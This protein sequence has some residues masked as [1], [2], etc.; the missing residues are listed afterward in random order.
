[1]KNKDDSIWKTIKYI[2]KE[3]LKSET[4]SPGGKLNLFFGI[5]IF[6]VVSAS[7]ASSIALYVC[8]FFKPDFIVGMPWYG[9]VILVILM[10][11]YFGY[12][13]HSIIEIDKLKN[14]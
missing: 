9:N 4:S 3:F 8:K 7:M 13:S 5:L 2:A 6:A 12:C 1:M 10:V 11:G 14:T